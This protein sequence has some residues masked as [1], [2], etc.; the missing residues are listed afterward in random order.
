M[1]VFFI[2]YRRALKALVTRVRESWR[3]FALRVR[4][5]LAMIWR[6]VL[7]RT[8]FIG[9]TGSCGKTT[10][11]ELLTCILAESAPTIWTR[12]GTNTIWAITSLVLRCRPWHRYAVAEVATGG[13]GS[14]ARS[15]RVL[16][17]D[18]G[19]VLSVASDHYA[20]FRTL[21]NTAREKADL[22]QSLR[23]GGVAYLNADDPL[24][25][26]M[27]APDGVK[28]VKFGR[29]D[30]ADVNVADV[31]SAW[32]DRLQFSIN[33]MDGNVTRIVTQLVGEHV[34]PS[35]LAPIAVAL[36]LGHDLEGIA[37]ISAGMSPLPGRMQPVTLPS[38][39]V[40]LRDE[41]KSSPQVVKAALAELRRASAARKIFVFGD[42]S[43]VSSSDRDRQKQVANWAAGIFDLLLFVGCHAQFGVDRAIRNG[44]EPK[45]A[46]GFA[47]LEKCAEFLQD[48]LR[49]GDLVLLKGR[50]SEHL[51]RLVF[52]LAGTVRCEKPW[53]GK[54]TFCDSCDELGADETVQTLIGIQTGWASDGLV[55]MRG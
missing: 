42:M 28:V 4:V 27:K 17:R 53:C 18:I 21:E 48:E 39:A 25:A 34:L 54:R 3:D 52:R 30:D 19:V 49:T 31:V 24:V 6:R 8:T 9:I 1:I 36:D 41:Y 55:K 5:V 51:S 7:W 10:T 26:R 38:G 40:V 47:S 35:V 23:A 2:Q 20:A 46:H 15:A 33:T 50:N 16:R 14:I 44:H 11:K 32:P 37:R 13:R 12:Q 43:D 29:A 45:Q 22:I